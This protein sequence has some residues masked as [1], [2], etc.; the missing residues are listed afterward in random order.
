MKNTKTQILR[1]FTDDLPS[2]TSSYKTIAKYYLTKA[3]RKFFINTNIFNLKDRQIFGIILR[4]K[5]EDNSIKT[6]SNMRRSNKSSFTLLS[7]LFKELLILR[8]ED[9]EHKQIKQIVFSYH[10]FSPD[11]QN[12]LLNE[13]HQKEIISEVNLIQVNNHNDINTMNPHNFILLPLTYA[14]SSI[15]LLELIDLNKNLDI[16]NNEQVQYKVK[17][18]KLDEANQSEFNLVLQSNPQIVIYSFKDKFI[19]IPKLD[20]NCSLIERKFNNEIYL[21]DSN[22]GEVVSINKFNLNK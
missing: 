2:I 21:I 22:K 15:F 10:I 4:V 8:A 7:T 14:G 16:K 19:D 13:D 6:L 11:N 18:N 17:V 20:N 1:E 3:L 9:Y 12:I 5:Y